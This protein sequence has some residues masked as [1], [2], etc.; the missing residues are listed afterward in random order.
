MPWASCA[1][2]IFSMTATRLALGKDH[3]GKAAAAMPVQVDL[4]LAHVGRSAGHVVR[5]GGGPYLHDSRCPPRREL[6]GAAAACLSASRRVYPG[7][8]AA[9]L[10]GDF[11][12]RRA[13]AEKSP[14]T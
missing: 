14:A 1:W 2:K 3:F 7:G 11:P 9:L 12:P 4:G 5:V 10:G 13:T 8:L 6:A